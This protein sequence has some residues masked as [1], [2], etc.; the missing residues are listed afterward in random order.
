MKLAFGDLIL[1]VGT[2]QLLGG[3]EER[4]LSPKAFERLK[5]LVAER[6]R[7]GSK[8]ALGVG[9]GAETFGAGACLAALVGEV[10]EVG[11]DGAEVRLESKNP[12]HSL[13][14]IR[15]LSMRHRSFLKGRSASFR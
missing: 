15:A 3:R 9:V 5:L 1:D 7:A 8:H 2:R 12:T 11:G 13:L 10:R 6:A 4:R 14:Y